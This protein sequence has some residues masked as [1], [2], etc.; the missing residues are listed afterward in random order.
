MIRRDG[1]APPAQ[2]L[3]LCRNAILASFFRRDA[4]AAPAPLLRPPSCR[5]GVAPPAQSLPT[6]VGRGTACGGGAPRGDQI[7]TACVL[8]MTCYQASGGVLLF[9]RK[10]P[11]GTRL[12]RRGIYAPP[13][14]SLGLR[15]RNDTVRVEREDFCC[16]G[17]T[18]RQCLKGCRMDWLGR[19]SVAIGVQPTM[20]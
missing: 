17:S 19:I 2:C 7:A 18:I 8:A 11:R 10:H 6:A 16:N 1:D 15:Q 9:N 12:P 14:A 13:N 4:D 5:G 3:S 20:S